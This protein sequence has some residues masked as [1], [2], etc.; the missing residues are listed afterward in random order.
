MTT[1]FLGTGHSGTDGLYVIRPRLYRPNGTRTALVYLHAAGEVARSVQ[2]LGLGWTAKARVLRALVELTGCPLV[3]GDF[4]APAGSDGPNGTNHWGAANARN[5]LTALIA[6]AKQV[7]GAGNGW[8]GIGAHAGPVAAITYS[9]GNVLLHTFAN[10]NPGAFAAAVAVCGV[11]D[12][13]DIRDNN[14][15]GNLRPSIEAAL[16][17][18]PWTAPRTPPLPAG[19]N[20]ATSH[21][22]MVGVPYRH[23]Y[24]TADTTVTPATVLA[25]DAALGASADA[26][27]NGSGHGDG[28]WSAID[29]AELAAWLGPN[30]HLG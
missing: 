21:A 1:D 25:L 15:G 20:P 16:G 3:A 6:H 17:V 9:M 14:R 24:G 27:P 4:G 28:N 29:P 5:L 10:A 30:L 7:P 2:D 19:A 22:G 11:S 18:G 12:V 23:Y 8:T 13:D 26:I